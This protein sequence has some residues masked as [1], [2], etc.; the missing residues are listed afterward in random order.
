MVRLTQLCK[1]QRERK[2]VIRT[3]RFNL[4]SAMRRMKESSGR[5]IALLGQLQ[6]ENETCLAAGNVICSKI[7][8]AVIVCDPDSTTVAAAV[9]S[10]DAATTA[11]TNT[12]SV[13]IDLIRKAQQFNDVSI[14][15]ENSQ[16]VANDMLDDMCATHE[17]AFDIHELA[18][19]AIEKGFG[20]KSD[21]RIPCA[22]CGEDAEPVYAART[23]MCMKC[24]D[25][26]RYESGWK[27]VA[28]SI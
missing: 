21:Y 4:A 8:H 24:V 17:S 16:K 14:N 11:L 10:I 5:A 28:S 1:Q 15:L 13:S 2:E 27:Q 20:T 6:N 18:V 22:G 19:N 26:N 23:G 12:S 25:H 9:A 7:Q 3:T